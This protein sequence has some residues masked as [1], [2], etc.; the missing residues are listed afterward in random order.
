MPFLISNNLV[1]RLISHHF[2]DM[3]SFPLRNAHFSTSL[4]STPNLKMFPLH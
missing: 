2:K 4:R 1:R 3:A